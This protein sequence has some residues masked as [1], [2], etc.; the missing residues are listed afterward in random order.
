MRVVIRGGGGVRITIGYL[1]AA[2][3]VCGLSLPGFAGVRGL[4]LARGDF[5][6]FLTLLT[7]W[8]VLACVLVP[9]FIRRLWVREE[10]VL[11]SILSGLMRD[12]FNRERLLEFYFLFE[13]TVLPIFLVISGWGY[14][15]ERLSAGI[16]IFFYTL[17]GSLP[18]LGW[19][20]FIIKSNW[21]FG[22]CSGFRILRSRGNIV[23]GFILFCSAGVLVKLPI[24]LGHLWLP[25]AHV[26]APVEG[27]IIL[28]SVILK[29]G[30]FGLYFLRPFIFRS[31]S[32]L[33]SFLLRL[34]LGGGALRGLLAIIQTDLKV[35]IAYSSVRHIGLALGGFLVGK[36]ISLLSFLGVL[37]SHGFVSS[38]LF[39]T[40]NIAYN[41]ANSR[42]FLIVKS[43]LCRNY[44]YCIVIFII[45]V[46]NMGGPPR[47]NLL[48]ELLSRTRLLRA[49]YWR[50]LPLRI[51]LGASTAYRVN[52][53]LHLTGGH[54]KE[55]QKASFYFTRSEV[56]VGQLHAVYCL[57]GGAMLLYVV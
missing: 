38:G 26:E 35:F 27:S 12:C 3:V 33:E 8:G 32:R 11:F 54:P 6:L 52:W 46:G 48:R 39:F 4:W 43:L 19:T 29:L 5:R 31:A 47:G 21:I 28:A 16:R 7:L 25:R 9:C 23:W 10:I 22:V 15:P 20:L 34:R 14:Q 42:N 18:L 56:V 37:L 17:G 2:I 1:C 55:R 53:Y 13:L 36:E 49:R 45:A 51:I 57:L 50:T 41:V 30:G 44:L 40:S 24:F